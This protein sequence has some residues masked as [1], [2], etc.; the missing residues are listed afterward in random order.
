MK[1]QTVQVV[2]GIL[3]RHNIQLNRIEYLF[4]QRPLG[5]DKPY[6]G[7]WEFAGGKIEE[8]ETNIQALSRE[9]KEELGIEIDINK[10]DYL[11]K[12]THDYAHASVELHFYTVNLWQGEPKGIEGQNLLWCT[13]DNYPTPILPSLDY[14]IPK[15]N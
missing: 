8:N 10:I 9:L 6:E 11:T 14:L 13:N 1:N 2:V 3:K 7:Y 5:N 15:L 4:N 12:T